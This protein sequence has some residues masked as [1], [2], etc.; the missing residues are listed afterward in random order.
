MRL[1]TLM[2]PMPKSPTYEETATGYAIAA[3]RMAELPPDTIQQ[4]VAEMRVMIDNSLAE[5]AQIATSSPY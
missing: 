2:S 3:M 1:Q 5:A 4:V